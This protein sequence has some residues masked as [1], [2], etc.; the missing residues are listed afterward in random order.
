MNWTISRLHTHTQN[1]RTSTGVCTKV[2]QIYSYYGECSSS[3][4]RTPIREYIK[5]NGVWRQYMVEARLR[6][7]PQPPSKFLTKFTLVML[8]NRVTFVKFYQLACSSELFMISKFKRIINYC[9]VP[10]KS[11]WYDIFFIFFK[12]DIFIFI[13]YCFHFIIPLN[14]YIYCV[15]KN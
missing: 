14:A 5:I 11:E 7:W 3:R 12:G 8:L 6:M 2:L 15:I 1:D 9:Y 4:P 13:Q 10:Q